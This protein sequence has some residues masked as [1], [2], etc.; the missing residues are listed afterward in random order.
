MSV[1]FTILRPE[2]LVW[3]NVETQNLILDSSDA[4]NPVLKVASAS[5]PAYLVFNFPPQSIA[6]QAFFEEDPGNPQEPPF[7]NIPPT[8]PQLPITSD[9][10]LVPGSVQA[11]MAG[12]SRLVFQLPSGITSIPYQTAALLN[13]K[14]LQ[15]VVSAA[16]QGISQPSIP[17]PQ[18]L[19]TAVELPFRLILSPGTGVAWVGATQPVTRDG[20]AELWHARLASAVQTK[21]AKGVMVT[22]FHEA[23]AKNTIPLRAI[24]SPDFKPGPGWPD[25]A[26]QDPFKLAALTPNDRAQIV[27]LTSGTQGYTVLTSTGSA[28]WTPLPIQA[29][30]FFLSA[31]GGWLSSEGRWPSQPQF[32]YVNFP[33]IKG[34][35]ALPK[36]I[37]GKVV[38]KAFVASSVS[39]PALAPVAKPAALSPLPVPIRPIGPPRP[40][41]FPSTTVT[42]DIGEWNHLATQG[43]DH[44]VRVVYEGYLYPF[45][46]RASLVKVTERKFVAADDPSV[47][48]GP[49]SVTAY[50]RQHMYIVVREPELTYDVS[51][52][53]GQGREM[54]FYQS[55]R[56]ETKVTPDINQPALPSVG[57][58]EFFWV[59]VDNA[60]FLFHVTGKDL[61]N[62]S[63]NFL[64]PMM[65]VSDMA[66][67]LGAMGG[68]TPD[69]NSVQ[70]QYLLGPT[71]VGPRPACLVDGKK[72]AF[73]S[74][75]AGD[76]QLR[77]TELYFD[78]Q[79]LSAAAATPQ[80]PDLPFMPVLEMATV[81]VPAIEEMLG[82]NSP[83][84]IEFYPPYIT[85]GL[86]AFAG[87]FARI[88]QNPPVPSPPLTV[89][90]TGQ[91]SGGFATP[92]VTVTGLSARKGVIA[93]DIDNAADGT[94]VPSDFFPL[95]TN[96]Y[97]FGVIPLGQLIPEDSGTQKNFMTKA[98]EI[99]TKP[100][101][102]AAAP[103]QLVTAIS[104]SPPVTSYSSSSI[105]INFTNGNPASK[106]T[107]NASITRMLDGSPGST[108]VKGEITNFSLN[109]LSVVVLQVNSIT[110]TSLN[111]NKTNVALKLPNTGAVTFQGPLGFVQKLAEMLPPG[112]FGGSGPSIQLTS[113]EIK[114]LFTLGLPPISIGVFT[115]EHIAITTGVDLPYL[116]GQPAF[117]FAFASRSK[118]FLLTVE[119]LGGGGFV[120][121]ILNAG[122]IQLVEA[123]LEFGGMFSLDLG[124]ASGGVS[125][126]AGIYFQLAGGVTTVSGFVDISGEVSVLGIISISIDLNLSLT[127]N[128]NGKIEGKATLTISVGILFF[129]ISVQL[130]V[131]RSFGSGAG[132][133]RAADVITAEDWA[134]YAL[135]FAA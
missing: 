96:A 102:N 4:K 78:A 17:Q 74:P 114:V 103:T 33:I 98:P 79:I 53:A 20:R 119:C 94:F 34:P 89:G 9:P 106:L 68:G 75:A 45:G 129:S 59:E 71:G 80:P 26:S 1:S 67:N 135:A 132:D 24:W 6:E 69:P 113:T 31:L 42:L 81:T 48:A 35:V 38:A 128:S 7:N 52:Y 85:P 77:T 12:P 44:Y 62:A 111:G 2:D 60:P 90:F 108:S 76:T 61:A 92:Q 105:G 124:V 101:P 97:L 72:I 110:F 46:H 5:S 8:S 22:S 29:S 58:P 16:A 55:I 109:I 87:V 84:T 117:E 116:N 27:V 51:K 121:V 133:P 50:L 63:I 93:G 64:A 56:I 86:D 125:V 130:T 54:P 39:R 11:R 37:G 19:E 82:V 88:A 36:K 120:H 57:A 73:A 30:R 91:Q 32:S 65:F 41:P 43:R 70:A 126:M 13:W 100:K 40:L 66:T 115:L 134:A 95:N 25:P 118:P 83:V 21:N 28:P 127:W 23:S 10:L 14:S 104:W 18:P 112:I 47:P 107:L 122:G 15:L 49:Y 3:L 99:R 131:E 123:A